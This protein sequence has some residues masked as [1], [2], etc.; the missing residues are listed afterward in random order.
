VISASR[1]PE[2]ILRSPIA[3]E[4]LTSKRSESPAASFY[5]TLENV[6]GLQLLTSSL[7]LKF[8]IPEVQFS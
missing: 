4:R 7:T 5:E 1:V 2:K 8:P 6:K 3:I